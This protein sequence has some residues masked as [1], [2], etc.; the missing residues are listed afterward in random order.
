MRG[1]LVQEEHGRVGEQRAGEHQALALA[2]GELRPLL[3]D[4]RVEPVGERGDPVAEPRAA[5]RSSELGVGRLGPREPEVLADRGVEQVR[6]LA[7]EGE[8]GA[9]VLLAVL[10]GVAAGDRDASLA[11]GRGSAGAGS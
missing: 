10:A 6:V 4:E 5:E 8:R 3:A 11:R 2:A 9:D 7:G 1:R